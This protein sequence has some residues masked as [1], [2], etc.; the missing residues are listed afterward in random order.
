MSVLEVSESH[1][2]T[3]NAG[4]KTPALVEAFTSYNPSLFQSGISK[5]IASKC[6]VKSAVSTR[7]GK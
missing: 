1:L 2:Y 7:L 3:K 4:S 6:S 5:F